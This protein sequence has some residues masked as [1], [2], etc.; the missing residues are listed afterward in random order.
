IKMKD[1]FARRGEAE[2]EKGEKKKPPSIALR[3][4]R[5]AAPPEELELTSL[6]KLMYPDAGITKGDVIDY[7]RQIAP[8]LLPY[9]KDRP[10]TL[11]RLPEGVGEGR[12]HFWQKNTPDSYPRLGAAR[13]IAQRGRQ[14]RPLRAGQRRAGPLVPGQPGGADLPRLGLAGR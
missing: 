7:Y 5:A 9:L 2:E 14:A 13:R 10:V 4:R 3:V 12:P 11:E 8:R 6:D 1:E